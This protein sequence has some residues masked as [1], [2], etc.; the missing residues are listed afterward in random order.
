MKAIFC[1]REGTY[2]PPI[3]VDLAEHNYVMVLRAVGFDR[4]VLVLLFG[5]ETELEDGVCRFLSIRVCLYVA[6]GDNLVSPLSTNL[7]WLEGTS[8]TVTAMSVVHALSTRVFG[9]SDQAVCRQHL[10]HDR[11]RAIWRRGRLGGFGPQSPSDRAWLI[12]RNLHV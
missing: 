11:V 6:L 8:H 12:W 7:A 3:M 10:N 2:L 1:R 4:G 9:Q 5:G